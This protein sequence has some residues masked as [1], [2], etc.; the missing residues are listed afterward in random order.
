MNLPVVTYGNPVL[1]A[2]G[3]PVDP[4][5]PDLIQLAE[6]MLESMYAHDG[7][8][9][10]A[11]QIGRPL[12]LFVLDVPQVENRPS[13][14]WI[15]GKEVDM[16]EH[17]PMVILNPVIEPIGETETETE[18]CLSFPEIT[19]DI[20]RPGRVRATVQ[21]LNKGTFE[22]EAEGLLA[23][24]LQHENDHLQ[25]ILFI[26]RMSSADKASLRSKL[27]RMQKQGH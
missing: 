18:G 3:S 26:D 27:K 11:Q 12:Q 7:I 4:A 19:A 21:L 16:A 1:R 10:A 9:L 15:E 22:F 2:K 14:M 17:M 23:R 8:G 5:D 25:G 6:G 20:T 24:A 13:R